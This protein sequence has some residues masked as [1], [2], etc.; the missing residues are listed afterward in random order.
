MVRPG[1]APNTLT[2][3][4]LTWSLCDAEPNDESRRLEQMY[5]MVYM[6]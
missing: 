1:V 3:I 2:Y 5:G 6:E 4:L